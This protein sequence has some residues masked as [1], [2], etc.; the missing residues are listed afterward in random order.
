[1]N[2]LSYPLRYL[3]LR[4]E[5]GNK[6]YLRDRSF[7]LGMAAVISL[8]FIVLKGNF[9][10]IG[11]MLDRV[12]TFASVLTGFYIAA[13]VGV[14][15]LSP[16]VGDLDEEIVEGPILAPGEIGEGPIRLTRR[17]YVCSLFGYLAFVSLFVS[18][19]AILAVVCSELFTPRLLSALQGWVSRL[20][21]RKADFLP[22]SL[23]I[24]RGLIVVFYSL[25]VSH[26]VTT[27]CHGLYYYIDRIYAKKTQMGS[28]K[29]A[30]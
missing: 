25:L 30:P 1:M 5:A 6:L 16:S 19:S 12:G 13:L 10:G 20:M 29:R 23:E 2:I 27:T 17:Q 11:G 22:I 9:F 21:E 24:F 18:V 8:P 26:I 3:A 4:A 7:V 15:S 28:K 14:A